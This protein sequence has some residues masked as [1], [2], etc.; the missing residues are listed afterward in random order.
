M[1]NIDDIVRPPK[2][3]PHSKNHNSRSSPSVRA[4]APVDRS[5]ILRQVYGRIEGMI[6][7]PIEPF[8]VKTRNYQTT[9]LRSVDDE[10]NRSFSLGLTEFSAEDAL[11]QIIH[12]SLHT[13][14][15]MQRELSTVTSYLSSPAVVLSDD[16]EVNSAFS[17]WVENVRPS[18]WTAWKPQDKSLLGIAILAKRA[19]FAAPRTDEVLAGQR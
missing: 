1:R 13:D 17:E 19:A 15:S 6:D 4:G 16:I 18:Y 14:R 9:D 7:S 8:W 11:Q 2:W 10:L 3:S 5:K 12:D